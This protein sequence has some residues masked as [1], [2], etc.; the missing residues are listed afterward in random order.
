MAEKP[1][2]P[3]ELWL[4]YRFGL[5][6]SRVGAKLASRYTE[7]HDLTMSAWRSLAVIARFGPLS[8]GELGA[9]TSTDAFKVTRAVEML[10][11]RGLIT[12]E[13]DPQDRRRA[14]LQLTA[15]GRSVYQDIE[16]SAVAIEHHLISTLTQAELRTLRNVL[17]KVDAQVETLADLSW[18][19]LQPKP[20]RQARSA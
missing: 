4:S 3:L 12:R 9:N 1:L 5:V 13:P 15:K 2:L 19:E 11:K 14:C 8:A 10:V 16:K 18:D 20:K 6:N 17:D 7:K